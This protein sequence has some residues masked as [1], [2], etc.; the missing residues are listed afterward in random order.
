M[1]QQ[2]V[3]LIQQGQFNFLKFAEGFAIGTMLGGDIIGLNLAQYMASDGKYDFS[4]TAFSSAAGYIGGE[5]AP[6]VAAE[7]GPIAGGIAGNV[8]ANLVN[9]TGQIAFDHGGF[10]WGGFAASG[11]EGLLS[12]PG[13]EATNW[14]GLA[15]QSVINFGAGVVGQ[16]VS[17][18]ID[19]RTGYDFLALGVDAFGNALG[20]SIVGEMRQTSGEQQSQ[21]QSESLWDQAKGWANSAA[22]TVEGWFG[23]STNSGIK[24]YALPDVAGSVPAAVPIP[25]YS[26]SLESDPT[27]SAAFRSNAYQQIFPDLWN[28]AAGAVKGTGDWFVAGTASGMVNLGLTGGAYDPL[29]PSVTQYYQQNAQQ[30]SGQIYDTLSLGYG[31]GQQQPYEIAQGVNTIGNLAIGGVSLVKGLAASIGELNLLDFSGPPSG[32]WRA[33]LG[34]VGDLSQIKSPFAGGGADALA[35]TARTFNPADVDQ[36]IN[37]RLSAFDA[38]GRSKVF[39]IGEDQDFVQQIARQNGYTQAREIW[40]P[41]VNFNAYL[42][43]SGNLPSDLQQVSIDYNKYLIQRLYDAGYEFR[44]VG[45]VSGTGV[46]QSPW[47]RAEL[48]TLNNFG[49]KPTW[50]PATRP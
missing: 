36:F 16:T 15:V 13:S 50:V 41:S 7:L 12:S 3:Q 19:H 18:S 33:Q 29:D 25:Q 2:D 17:N 31:E 23:G 30:M 34:S 28:N 8:S 49:V 27:N 38:A 44:T 5:I 39:L 42:D 46:I 14:A 4:R 9:Q 20:N 24:T 43:E 37:D 35:S 22:N 6:V 26:F 45:T 40:A 21:Q 1:V 32:S 11:M 48:E 47:Y 10:D